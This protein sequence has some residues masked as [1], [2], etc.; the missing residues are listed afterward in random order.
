MVTRY[1]E[2]SR[3]EAD[4]VHVEIVKAG[5]R[6]D[7]SR[8]GKDR[9]CGSSTS[10][11]T[12][13]STPFSTTPTIPPNVTACS[14]PC[15]ASGNALVGV[16]TDLM[17]SEDR[18]MLTVVADTCGDHDTLGSA[19]SCESNMIRY[20]FAHRYQHACRESF[21]AGCWRTGWT[22]AIRSTT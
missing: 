16:G 19:C 4:A 17:S 10:T 14:R 18:V 7:V 8:S 9:F 3:K 12:R 6:L 11:A 1:L 5:N 13:R 20:G 15:S 2:S 21:L 22:S